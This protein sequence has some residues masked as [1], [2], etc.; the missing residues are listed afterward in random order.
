MRG[1]KTIRRGRPWVTVVVVALALG[2]PVPARAVTAPTTSMSA[3][4]SVS[5]GSGV[6]A[7]T[8]TSDVRCYTQDHWTKGKNALGW[9][10]WKFTQKL[11]LCWGTA[12]LCP[13]RI[14]A[15]G[16]Y[17]PRTRL[18]VYTNPLLLWSWDGVIEKYHEW[19]DHRLCYYR[20]TTGSF[21][22]CVGPACSH[23]YPLVWMRGYPC[24]CN[25]PSG[26]R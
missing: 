19:C 9:T 1:R 12:V 16:T 17:R 8:T 7:V 13:C 18:E 23:S 25:W 6:G 20:E 15:R 2:M 24:V 4:A 11:R 3:L 22:L 14:I 5:S 26:D 21:S 10:L